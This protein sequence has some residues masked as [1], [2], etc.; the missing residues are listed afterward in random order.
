MSEI[1]LPPSVVV[2]DDLTNVLWP[3]ILIH[4]RIF[5][6]EAIANVSAE[7]IPQPF[8]DGVGETFFLPMHHSLGKPLLRRF[9][10]Q[11]FSIQVAKF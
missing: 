4:C 8:I 1:V 3:K 5:P 11:V 2:G 6:K 7:P 9:L 10:V